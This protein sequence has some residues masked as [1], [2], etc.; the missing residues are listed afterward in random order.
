MN[1][2]NGKTVL[3]ID[4]IFLFTAYFPI[5]VIPAGASSIHLS[6][7]DISQNYLAVRSIFGK[8]FLNGDWHL[9]S[10]GTYTIGGATFIYKR[11]YR[12]PESLSSEGP[13]TEDIVLEV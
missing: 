5:V 4:N 8:Y 7:R 6:E 1:D 9:T 13:T 10:E 12:E 11:S 2:S 3:Y